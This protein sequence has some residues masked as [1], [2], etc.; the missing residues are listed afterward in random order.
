MIEFHDKSII[1]LYVNG[2]LKTVAARPADTLLFILRESLGLTGTKNSCGNGDCNSC[3]VLL[4][5]WPV[6]SCLMLAV[7]AVG[8]EITTI[9]G[10]QD[11]PMQ[12]A[13]VE[14]S[15]IQCGYCT[16]GMI[17]NSHAL[18]TIYPD[19]SDEIIEEWLESNICRCTGYKEICEAVKSVINM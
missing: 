10:L 2:D 4:D 7:E 6:K 9:E 12:K 1:E 17:I 5:G 19:A 8:H 11:V 14:K 3:T 18:T 13:F 15:A 16:P